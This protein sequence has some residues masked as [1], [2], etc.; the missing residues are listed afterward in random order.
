MSA[1]N[2][3]GMAD[4]LTYLQDRIEEATRTALSL[5]IVAGLALMTL[6]WAFAPVIASF[7]HSTHAVFVIRGFAVC[8]PFDAS[9]QVPIGRLTRA[10]NFR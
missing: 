6:T 8:L 1:I 4:A 7:F 2:E 3:L 5:V 10:L 9:A